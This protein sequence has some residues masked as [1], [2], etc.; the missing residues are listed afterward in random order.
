MKTFLA[1]ELQGFFDG[2]VFFFI[3]FWTFQYEGGY[4]FQK[5]GYNADHWVATVC[6][7]TAM[8]ITVYLNLLVRIR[9]ITLIHLACMTIG[10]LCVYEIYLWISNYPDFSYQ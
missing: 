7:C 4:I 2:A 6:C 8:I 9:Y 10:G 3:P 1:M 5:H